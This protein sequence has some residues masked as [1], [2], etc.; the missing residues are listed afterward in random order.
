M[1][2][3]ETQIAIIKAS[4]ANVVHRQTHPLF[5]NK[6][7]FSFEEFMIAWRIDFVATLYIY[8]TGFID[9]QTKACN[10]CMR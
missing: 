8:R 10:S 1:L 9:D 3:I 7:M 2:K 4:L 5:K 6:E